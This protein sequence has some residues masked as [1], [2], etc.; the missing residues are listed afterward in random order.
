MIKQQEKYLC[1]REDTKSNQNNTTPSAAAVRNF[2]GTN[3]SD[4]VSHLLKMSHRG[5][6]S[7]SGKCISD[8]IIN[9]ITVELP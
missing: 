5:Y 7:S 9:L 4:A 3:D 8:F 6:G 2:N 1:S